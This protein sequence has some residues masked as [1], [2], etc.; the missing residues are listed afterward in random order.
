MCCLENFK[1]SSAAGC[2][3]RWPVIAFCLENIVYVHSSTGDFQFTSQGR[4]LFP[5]PCARHFTSKINAS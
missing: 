1:A 2:A 4:P 3:E 5:C